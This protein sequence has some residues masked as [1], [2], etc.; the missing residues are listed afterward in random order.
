MKIN[1]GVKITILYTAF[2]ALIVCMVT[3]AMREK[4]D[5]ES[6]DYYEQEIKFQDKINR[7]EL[8]K[9]LKEPLTWEVRQNGLVLHIPS[10]FRGR[11]IS[12]SIYFFRPSDASMDKTI[13]FAADTSLTRNISTASL[14]HGLYKMQVNWTVNDAEYLNEGIIQVH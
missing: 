3:M 10:E 12:G 8:T 14:T 1:W 6:K 5:L 11:N 2:V 4:V 13:A 9:K 7:K